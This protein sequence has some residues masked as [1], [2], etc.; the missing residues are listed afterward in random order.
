VHVEQGPEEVHGHCHEMRSSSDG[1]VT[2]QLAIPGILLPVL[3][4]TPDEGQI[5]L[6]YGRSRWGYMW[7]RQSRSVKK[8]YAVKYSL[9][10]G[11]RR[12]PHP[13]IEC[14]NRAHTASSKIDVV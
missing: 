8:R 11:A 5:L 2:L 13:Y 1:E 12:I 9:A 7:S 4:G 6:R 14:L 10:T 3:V